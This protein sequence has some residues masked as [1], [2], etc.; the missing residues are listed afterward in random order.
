[1]WYLKDGGLSTGYINEHGTTMSV[2]EDGVGFRIQINTTK[3]NGSWTT[4][5]DAEN[6]MAKL[7]QGF[8]PSIL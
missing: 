6:A 5:S 7:A 2:T 8:D 4:Q 3:V 1:M